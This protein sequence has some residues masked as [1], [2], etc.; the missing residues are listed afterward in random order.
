MVTAMSIYGTFCVI[1]L[2]ECAH[3]L[4]VCSTK[5][6]SKTQ[7]VLQMLIAISFTEESSYIP[8]DSWELQEFPNP[9]QS[10]RITENSSE[11]FVI[12]ETHDGDSF[13]FWHWIF[14]QAQLERVVGKWPNVKGSSSARWPMSIMSTVSISASKQFRRQAFM[15]S[16]ISLG[17]VFSPLFSG[18]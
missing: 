18:C 2:F 4:S 9:S 1:V 13:P 14:Q 5:D 6:W 3:A 10:P 15:G 11:I 7:S 12:L 8:E 17:M 16:N